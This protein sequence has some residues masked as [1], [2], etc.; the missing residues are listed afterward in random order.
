MLYQHPNIL[1]ELTKILD[2]YLILRIYK[3]NHFQ[4]L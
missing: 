3:A 1:H 4:M 2:N